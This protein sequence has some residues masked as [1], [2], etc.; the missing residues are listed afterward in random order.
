MQVI[1][2]SIITKA[3]VLVYVNLLISYLASQ[4]ASVYQW[5]F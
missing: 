1:N 5:W 4:L 2:F 3:V